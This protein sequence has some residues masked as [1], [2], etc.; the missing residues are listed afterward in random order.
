MVA[1]SQLK[2]SI[3]PGERAAP[4]PV[5]QALVKRRQRRAA[6]LWQKFELTEGI[7]E[8]STPRIP[9][10]QDQSAFPARHRSALHR[11]VWTFGQTGRPGLRRIKIRSCSSTG[12]S[13]R[14]RT[15]CRMNVMTEHANNIK[16]SRAGHSI[17]HWEGDTLVVDTGR[18]LPGF[19][20]TPVRNSDKLHVVERFTLDPRLK[21]ALTRAYAAEDPVYLKGKYTGSDTIFV[22]D[23]PYSPGKCSCTQTSATAS[24][25]L[26][27]AH[28]RVTHSGLLDRVNLFAKG[29]VRYRR[30]AENRSSAISSSSNAG[31][32]TELRVG[33]SPICCD[34][35]PPVDLSFEHE[36]F[37]RF[38]RHRR[39]AAG[40]GRV[41]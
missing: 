13:T 6:A 2:P 9:A 22:A 32:L 19:L 31:K 26:E 16:P 17:G 15:I 30:I 27:C 38:E 3:E 4:T 10:L 40:E 24:Y 12:S 1:L 21:M 36:F 29:T 20:N 8:T 23:A 18:F 14:K 39:P 11:V 28:L 37:S 7:G 41:L 25:L 5:E 34:A 35:L 33:G